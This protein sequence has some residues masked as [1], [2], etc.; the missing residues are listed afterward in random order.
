MA[1]RRFVAR[2]GQVKRIY[3]DNGTNLRGGER[4]LRVAISQWN[5]EQIN[6]VLLQKE[7]E[8]YFSPPSASHFGGT[9]ERCIRTIRKILN[10]ISNEQQLDDESFQTLLIEVEAIINGRPLTKS[11]ESPNDEEPLTPNHLLL[12]DKEPSLPPG[13]FDKNDLYVR[14]R[15]RQVQYLTDLFWKRW[16]REYLHLLQQRT[17]WMQPQRNIRVDDVVLLVDESSPRNVWPIGRILQVIPDAQGLVRRVTVKT[18]RGVFERPIH[19][20]CLMEASD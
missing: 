13:M 7:I 17:K 16:T 15:W 8:W 19:K 20:L 6:N 1:L 11:S 2:R 3:S 10:A 9:W 18:S 12:L 4:E 5:Q 14:R